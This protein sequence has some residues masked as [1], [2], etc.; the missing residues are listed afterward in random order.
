MTYCTYPCLL[1][2]VTLTLTL[3]LTWDNS[4]TCHPSTHREKDILLISWMLHTSAIRYFLLSRFLSR[5]S[6]PQPH[7]MRNFMASWRFLIC[8]WNGSVYANST[9]ISK[10]CV[11]FADVLV[12]YLSIQPIQ[13]L[14]RQCCLGD[15]CERNMIFHIT[16]E[17]MF[18]HLQE[19]G[20]L[21]DRCAGVHVFESRII[22]SACFH[23]DDDV[24]W[25]KANFAH[26]DTSQLSRDLRVSLQEHM[27]TFSKLSRPLEIKL[28][29]Q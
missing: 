5:S 18:P 10:Y 4:C 21:L 2:V 28:S 8:R 20:N 9:N 27:F 13:L 24:H 7:T 22:S 11:V 17:Y 23:P 6:C 3:C 29:R 19:E 26:T 14:R 12:Q 1:I 25:G 16:H 15:S